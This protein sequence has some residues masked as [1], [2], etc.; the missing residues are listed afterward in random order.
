MQHIIDSRSEKR[1]EGDDWAMTASSL[2][3]YLSLEFEVDDNRRQCSY[4][5]S[6]RYYSSAL[7]V[8]N[9]I[10]ILKATP[11]DCLSGC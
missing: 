11:I 7:A 3:Q 10:K 4:D 8:L 1:S 2:K 6:V 9:P 5:D